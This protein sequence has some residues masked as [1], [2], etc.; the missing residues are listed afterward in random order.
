MEAPTP[1]LSLDEFAVAIDAHK[2][3]HYRPNPEVAYC[4]RQCESIIRKV[5]CYV[6]IHDKRFGRECAGSGQVVKVS[7]PYCPVCEGVPKKTS[8]CIHV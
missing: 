4:C 3:S 5:Y 7:L 8:S 6:S 1:G 2:E